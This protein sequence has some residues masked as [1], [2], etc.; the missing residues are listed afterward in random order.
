VCRPEMETGSSGGK[1]GSS[2]W[3][4]NLARSKG[5]STTKLPNSRTP[6]APC[7]LRGGKVIPL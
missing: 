4:S 7:T 2:S 3:C 6:A 5:S 1:L